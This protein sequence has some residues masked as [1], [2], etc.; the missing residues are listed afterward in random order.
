[1]RIINDLGFKRR[2]YDALFKNGNQ[3]S[4]SQSARD[5]PIL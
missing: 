5:K 4:I 1:M 2:K 3:L